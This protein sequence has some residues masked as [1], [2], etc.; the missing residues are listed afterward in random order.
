MIRGNGYKVLVKTLGLMCLSQPSCH[1]FS[2][3]LTWETQK[4]NLFLESECAEEISDFVD[5]L[6]GF[7]MVSVVKMIHG[8][9]DR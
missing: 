6:P 8:L 3:K 7:C 2:M 1:P 5:P 9:L 4:T